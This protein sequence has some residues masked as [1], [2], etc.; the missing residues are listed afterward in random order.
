MQTSN[1]FLTLQP[2]FYCWFY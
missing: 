1:Q 2:M